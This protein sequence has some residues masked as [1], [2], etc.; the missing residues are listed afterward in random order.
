MMLGC[1]GRFGGGFGPFGSGFGG[2]GWMLFMA[3]RF[4]IFG[5]ILFAAYRFVRRTKKQA[6]TA[7]ALS[8]L[9]DRYV[10]GEINE[11]EYLQRKSTLNQ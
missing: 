10:R 5:L 4:L 8:L 11:E 1:F 2:N 7:D 3:G 6:S 9:N